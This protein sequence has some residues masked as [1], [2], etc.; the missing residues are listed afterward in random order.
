MNGRDRDPFAARPP[1]VQT[2]I[3]SCDQEQL[4]TI[5]FRTGK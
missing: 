5:L 2:K 3:R 1:K 4:T